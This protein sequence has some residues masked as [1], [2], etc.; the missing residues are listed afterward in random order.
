[1]QDCQVKQWLRLACALFALGAP[2]AIAAEPDVQLR[3]RIPAA[4]THV[5]GDAIP[6]YFQF[7]N[8]ATNPLAFMWEGCCRFNGKLTVTRAGQVI[9]PTPPGQALAHMFA[10]AE[11][12][13][14]GVPKDFET[15]LSD[16]VL[17]TNSGTYELRGHYQGVLPFQNPQV[18]RG[19]ELWR[20][21]A[22]S[23]PLVF[24]VLSVADY[25]A[26]RSARAR[27]R[28]LALELS[29]PARLPPLAPA[30][31]KLTISNRSKEP[32]AL[33]WP[34]DFQLWLVNAAG[35]RVLAATDIAGAREE[36][37]LAPGASLERAIPFDARLLEGEPWG[38]YRVFV[39][40][41]ATRDG[42][43]RAPSNPVS[44][45]WEL[46]NADVLALLREA[47]SGHQ[48]GLRN[49]PL[50]LLRVYV[51]E[52]LPALDALPLDS[53]SPEAARLAS[54]LRIAGCLKPAQPAP[55]LLG[56]DTRIPAR[57][58]WRFNAP[59]VVSC[60][61]GDAIGA[62]LQ[63]TSLLAVRRHLG[64]EV[65]LTLR[66]DDETT[67]LSVRA[68]LSDLADLRAELATEPRALLPLSS[69]R[70]STLGFPTNLP[71][72]NLVFRLD[73][74]R[75]EFVR[76]LPDPDNPSRNLIAP[77]SLTE[78]PFAALADAAALAALLADGQLPAPRIAILASDRLTWRQ[79]LVRL[80]PLLQRGVAAD[81][82]IR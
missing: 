20:G 17:L 73:P 2:A 25:L 28:G 77:E 10:K 6:L 35:A 70:V 82:L 68:A 63:L 1:M 3:L 71:P 61:G 27:A 11:R 40:L 5:I 52:I 60:L 45:R 9:P 55:G 62:K 49:A 19:L 47:A 66:T 65:A 38:D 51:A 21:T 43:S 14:P 64:W 24:P 54:Q 57:G 12:L 50:K 41:T 72:A 81:V 59:L 22:D 39:E 46:G 53:L 76:R 4:A 78:E 23:P 26:Q 37:T 56:L 42:R 79:L 34:D 33:V 48:T 75:L 58:P 7:E 32:R 69:N 74:D 15:R 16:W 44:L 29:G 18:P 8:R 80:D 36:L 30:P 31:L 67:L 13:D